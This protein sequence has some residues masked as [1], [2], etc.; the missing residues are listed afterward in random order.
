MA[1]FQFDQFI[2]AYRRDNRDYTY[3]QDDGTRV[4][5]IAGE[6]GVTE[7]WIA[8]LKIAHREERKSMRRGEDKVCSLEEYCEELDDRSEI[9]LDESGD[10]E[11]LVLE[12][13]EQAA[14]RERLRH[15]LKSL[16][17]RQRALLFRI[18][19]RGDT[20]AAIAREEGVS[21]AAIWKRARNAMLIFSKQRK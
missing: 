19:V 16:T 10:P 8:R 9:L 21:E 7:E 20:Y 14:S 17:D 18:A 4:T 12:R 5:L 13:F 15:G 1:K 11:R 2:K 3:W 6:D